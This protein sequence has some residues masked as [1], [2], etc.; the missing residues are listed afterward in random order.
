MIIIEAK[1]KNEI[2]DH[3]TVRGEV[4]I[5]GQNIDWD[6]EFDGLDK[7]CVLF[8]AY[9]DNKVI[10]AARMYNNKVGR[11]AVLEKYRRQGVGRE[12]MEYIE[13]YALK[14]NIKEL[15]LNSQTYISQFYEELGYK[16]LG[17]VFKEAK[18]DHIKMIKK[19]DVQTD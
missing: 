10:G 18:I 13:L 1:T 4:F 6:E 5:I 15:V 16:K 19:I 9:L 14:H 11:V 3:F 8:N 12:I 7:D 17:D 2:I